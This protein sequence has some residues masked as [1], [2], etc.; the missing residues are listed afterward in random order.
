MEQPATQPS[1][2]LGR[3]KGL[4]I[5]GIGIVI[6]GALLFLV[7][8]LHGGIRTTR[9]LPPAEASPV[10]G[11]RG[12]EASTPSPTPVPQKTPKPTSQDPAPKPPKEVPKVAAAPKQG[13]GKAEDYDYGENK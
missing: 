10:E 7:V 9:D 1:G 6:V 8:N 3:R 5:G 4:V 2:W 12:E 11:T 13:A